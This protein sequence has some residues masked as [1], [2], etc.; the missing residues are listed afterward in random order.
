MAIQTDIE[1]LIERS[2]MRRENDFRKQHRLLQY[3]PW[4]GTSSSRSEEYEP[5]LA[6]VSTKATYRTEAS[7]DQTSVY[8]PQTPTTTPLGD[9]HIS[10]S[11]IE[12]MGSELYV[13][14]D[15]SPPDES[16]SPVSAKSKQK[17]PLRLRALKPKTH[18][19]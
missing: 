16:P 5:S 2:F 6:S 19:D 9:S 15:E 17:G 11:G 1:A 8:E 12:S 13:M 18:M 14:K 4:Y 3:T 10:D 7:G